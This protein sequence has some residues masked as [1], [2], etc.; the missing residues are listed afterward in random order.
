[1]KFATLCYIRKNNQTLMLHR[2]KK[3]NDMHKGKWNGLGGK[4]ED[5]ETPEEC[6]IR[7]IKEEAG[8]DAK[9]PQLKGILT[10]PAFDGFET[11]Y[12]FL[13][14]ITEFSGE[15]IESTEGNLEWIDNDKLFDLHLW[16]GDKIFMQWLN[17]EGF[18]SA[19]F[20]YD[21]GRLV[22]YTYEVY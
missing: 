17:Q 2:V 11:W 7:E 1:M 20:M 12:V 15:L 19:K 14:L 16:E 8:L 10:F 9:N 21:N 4:L 5:G 6:A 18:Y 13:F 22:D 3:K